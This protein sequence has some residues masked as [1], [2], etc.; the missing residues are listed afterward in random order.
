MFEDLDEL[1]RALAQNDIS[2]RQAMRWAGY[3]VLGATLSSMGFAETA[4]AL[5]R[6]QRRRCRKKGGIPLE[7]GNCHCGFNCGTSDPDRFTCQNEEFC[8]CFKTAEGKGFCADVLVDCG[9]VKACTRSSQCP[10]GWKC[11]V[12]GC[13]QNKPSGCLPPCGTAAGTSRV[14][15]MTLAGPR[16]A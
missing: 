3:S 4:E 2:R 11:V 8:N 15:G 5:T 9:A 6:R 7:K 13:C 14:S 10:T 16:G 12:N 1:A